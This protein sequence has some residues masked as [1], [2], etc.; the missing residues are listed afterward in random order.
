MTRRSKREIDSALDKLG[1]SDEFDIGD[2]L[3]VGAKRVHGADLTSDEERLLDSPEDYLS[4]SEIRYLKNMDA[5][6]QPTEG[7]T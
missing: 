2:Y 3:W 4:E 7:S 6:R 1:S 5:P